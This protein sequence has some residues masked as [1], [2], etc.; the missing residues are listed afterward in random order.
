MS[1]LSKLRRGTELAL[2][3]PGAKLNRGECHSL[4]GALEAAQA[5]EEVM[6]DYLRGEIISRELFYAVRDGLSANLRGVRP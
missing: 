6:T 5:A 4:V 1:I 2:G 3:Y